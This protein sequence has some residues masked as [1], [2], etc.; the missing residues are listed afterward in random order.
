MQFFLSE[1]MI[2]PH[3]I[4]KHVCAK[5]TQLSFAIISNFALK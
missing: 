2:Y 1:L 3:K 4:V 5:D